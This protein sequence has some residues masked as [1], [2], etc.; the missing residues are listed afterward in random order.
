MHELLIDD[1]D[2]P[3]PDDRIAKYPLEQR[4]L[5]KLLIWRNGEITDEAFTNLPN[6][7]PSDSL[8]VFN[9]TRVIRARLLFQKATGANIEIF[10]LEPNTPSDYALNFQQTCE[11]SWYCVVGNLKKWKS[12]E[13]QMPVFINGIQVDL[14]AEHIGDSPF[15]EVIR[16]SWNNQNFNFSDIIDAAGKIPIP[17]YLH[18]DADENDNT[19]YQTIYSKIK[20]SVAA[21]TAGLHFTGEVFDSLK[22]RG[23]KLLET[24]L[25]VGAGTFQPVKSSSVSDHEMHTEHMIIGR[26]VV[27]TL[28]AHT[29]TIIAVGTTSVRTLESI[30]W[31]G[32]KFSAN[33]TITPDDFTV[34]Q[35][36]P[37]NS[38]S[39]LSKH[40]SLKAI[41]R[42]M[43]DNGLDHLHASTQIIIVPG[44]SFRIIDGLITNFHQPKSTLLLLISA[45]VGNDWKGI[46]DH[47]LTHDYR[48]LS[49]GDSNL[50]LKNKSAIL[51]F[52]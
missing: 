24:T 42:F 13:L 15:S 6:Y 2:Y 9:N 25:H 20:G 16:F 4:D 51:T 32:C 40:D 45:F 47:A 35:W 48:F 46:Y 29:G 23:I 28:L 38:E 12:G 10:I 1:Y 36:E 14:K 39:E 44:Y 22:Q 17:P 5:S 43:D 41:L 18:R 31:L 26:S 19:R 7:L 33:P 27:E 52:V 30:Y 34:M 3:L 49:Y 50:Y 11:C 37:Y 21:P 8:L